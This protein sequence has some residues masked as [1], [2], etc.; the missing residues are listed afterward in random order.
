MLG[1]GHDGLK[2]PA[3]L[4]E[5]FAHLEGYGEGSVVQ[6]VARRHAQQFKAVVAPPL[7]KQPGKSF[8]R[9]RF[10]RA[11]WSWN[12]VSSRFHPLRRKSSA[13]AGGSSALSM[14]MSDASIAASS[15][16]SSSRSWS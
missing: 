4:G 13:W 9:E 11:R 10:E 6:V 15:L 2:Q 14:L 5:V 8:P 16:E 3:R 12:R 7:Y 1:A